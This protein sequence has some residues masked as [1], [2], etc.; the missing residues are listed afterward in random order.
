MPM[1][2]SGK[3]FV[4]AEDGGEGHESEGQGGKIGCEHCVYLCYIMPG[5]F[6]GRGLLLVACTREGT[7]INNQHRA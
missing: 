7:P 5:R 3:Q 2:E 1:S 4:G 6:N